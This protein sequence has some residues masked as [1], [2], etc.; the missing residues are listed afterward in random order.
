[1]EDAYWQVAVTD[2]MDAL[3]LLRP[4]FDA[5]AGTDGFV[6]L[7]IAPGLAHDTRATTAAAR[8]LHERIDEPNLLVKIPATSAG[9]TAIEATI[10]E[11][12]SI[13]VTLIFSLSRYRQVLE[14]HLAGLE[15]L[16]D[17]GRICRPST[18]W[19]RSS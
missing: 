16:A 3:E 19:P 8:D 2:V 11:G 14:A 4:T 5:S 10:A 7:E 17:R 6:S 13:H 18:A 9:V 12:R 15:H 1:V